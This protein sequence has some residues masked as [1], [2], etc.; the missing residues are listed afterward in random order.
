MHAMLMLMSAALAVAG[1]AAAAQA[2]QDSQRKLD[3]VTVQASA[4]G[5]SATPP[6]PPRN[7]GVADDR[8]CLK[9]TGSH[10]AARE[11][12]NGGCVMASGRSYSR[13]DIDRTGQTDLSQA[14]RMLDPAMR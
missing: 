12:R 13:E 2:V 4:R 1:N 8:H 14:L 3:A 9:Y 10:L 7:D 6:T 11:R 5:D